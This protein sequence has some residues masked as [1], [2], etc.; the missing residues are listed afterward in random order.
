LFPPGAA[1]RGLDPD[2]VVFAGFEGH[3]VGEFG[4]GA[5]PEEQ[6]KPGAAIVQQRASLVYTSGGEAELFDSDRVPGALQR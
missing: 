4:L 3:L 2:D 1:T 5:V 6:V